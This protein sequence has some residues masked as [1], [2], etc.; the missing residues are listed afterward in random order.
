MREWNTN[1]S[2]FR[3]DKAEK[4]FQMDKYHRLLFANYVRMIPSNWSTTSTS[5]W[6]TLS[7][8]WIFRTHFRFCAF[9]L[10]FFF[11]IILKLIP[12]ITMNENY[13]FLAF[14]WW[15]SQ[16]LHFYRCCFCCTAFFNTCF[17]KRNFSWSPYICTPP[18][19]YFTWAS[20]W[21]WST[22]RIY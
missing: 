19:P 7:I 8:N 4:K 12:L 2:S 3:F 21:Q 5:R 1:R 22:F 13:N 20:R 9:L 18:T 15:Y 6:W 17:N 14:R 10:L 16:G 11:V